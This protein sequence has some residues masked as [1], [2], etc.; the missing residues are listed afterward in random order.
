MSRIRCVPPTVMIVLGSLMVSACQFSGLNAVPL[1]GGA[2]LGDHPIH[3]TVN[4]ADSANLDRQASVKVD[5]VT[6]GTVESIALHGWVAEVHVAVADGVILPANATASV[7][8]T[9]LLGEKYL[10][11]AAPTMAAATGHLLD[12][13]VIPV[14]RTGHNIDVEQVLGALSLLLN[15]GGVAHLHTITV[16]LRRALDGRTTEVRQLLHEFDTFVGSLAANRK[17][18]ITALDAL[19]RFSANLNRGHATIDRALATIGPALKQLADERPQIQKLLAA[20]TQ[21]SDIGTRTI[22]ASGQDLVANLNSLEPILRRLADAGDD[23]PKSLDF[24]LSFP[25]PEKIL[26]AIK[27]DYVNA[28]IQIDASLPQLITM[29]QSMAPQGASK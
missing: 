28:N 14:A 17:A 13:A 11:L 10:E 1:P 4:L 5:D 29:L 26:T 22:Q 21:L 15:G 23:F 16:E 20:T 25:F 7:R 19:G 18:F 2:N 6:V 27:G 8:Q 12:G 3:I 24:M 9:G